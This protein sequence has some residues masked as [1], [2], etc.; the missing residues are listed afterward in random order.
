MHFKH[1]AL[2]NPLQCKRELLSIPLTKITD[3][4]QAYLLEKNVYNIHYTES[5]NIKSFKVKT[6]SS[7]P[8]L[9]RAPRDQTI[10]GPEACNYSPS[11]QQNLF[12]IY[13]QERTIH[14]NPPCIMLVNSVRGEDD[15]RIKAMIKSRLENSNQMK[16]VDQFDV[17]WVAAPLPYTRARCTAKCIMFLIES[18]SLIPDTIQAINAYRSKTDYPQTYNYKAISL[19]P[20]TITM[21]HTIQTQCKFQRSLTFTSLTGL[22]KIDIY[23]VIVNG[24][25]TKDTIPHTIAQQILNS[26]YTSPE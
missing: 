20:P 4:M 1:T 7:Y 16:A 12:R 19:T 26:S 15:H 6:T 2:L 21:D 23:T 22:N 25:K 8:E 9:G 17:L 24:D 3:S 10:K 11:L 14:G 18:H 13:K 5:G